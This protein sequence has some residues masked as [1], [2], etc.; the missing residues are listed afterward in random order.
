MLVAK[1]SGYLIVPWWRRNSGHPSVAPGNAAHED[2]TAAVKHEQ[3]R[4]YHRQ[5]KEQNEALEKTDYKRQRANE[6]A[7]QRKWFRPPPQAGK[8]LT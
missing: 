4:Q 7:W 6:D 3:Q 2:L 5:L 1:Q 8:R